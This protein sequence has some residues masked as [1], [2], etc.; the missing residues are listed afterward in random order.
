MKPLIPLLLIF[1]LTSSLYAQVPTKGMHGPLRVSEHNPRYFTDDRGDAIYLTGSHT[2]NN[3]VEMKSA[4][5]Q[6]DFDY[7]AYVKW[8]KKSNFNFMR[9]WA[10]ELLNWET[11]RN[12]I[13]NPQNLTVYPHRWARTGPGNAIDGKPKFDV[14][15]FNEVYFKRLIERIEMAGEYGIYVSIMLFEGWGIQFAPK[16]YENHPFHPANNIN[17]IVGDVDGDGKGLEIQSLA[18]SDVTAIQKEYV[19]R[20]INLVNE[21]DNVLYEISNESPGLSTDWQYEMV[22]FIKE[23]EQNLPKQHPVGMT[24][25]QKGGNNQNLFDSPA[26]WIS[27]N[28]EGGYRDNPPIGDGR[29]III[30]DTDHLWGLGGNE[31]WVWKSFFRGLNPILMDTD[32]G[33]VLAPKSLDPDWVD[34]LRKSMGYTLLL[35]N[36]IDLISMKPDTTLVS[37]A[38]C[39]ANKGTEYLIYLPEDKTVEVDLSGITGD[40]T[41]EWFNP[42]LGEFIEGETIEGGDRISMTSPSGGVNVILHLLK[43]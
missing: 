39:L 17:G 3:L 41:S 29:K 10:W 12:P 14:T 19:K 36:R 25:Q 43:K 7:I 16:A 27:P 26:D 20:V 23:Y 31:S 38:Y 30:S 18:N 22:N 6:P 35:A 4:D 34:P 2:W 40:F 32:D 42:Q 15:K 37:S 9:L 11:G 1:L 33:K 5:S 21:F 8:M 28:K 24:F 13:N